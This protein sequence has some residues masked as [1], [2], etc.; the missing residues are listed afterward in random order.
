MEHQLRN[1]QPVAFVRLRHDPRNEPVHRV[2]R[3]ARRVVD[4]DSRGYPADRVFIPQR[5]SAPI[6]ARSFSENL[7]PPTSMSYFS[8]VYHRLDRGYSPDGRDVWLGF[9]FDSEGNPVGVMSE[10]EAD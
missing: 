3:R 5:A 10:E 9:L 4:T 2:D 7:P 8:A 6:G 1:A